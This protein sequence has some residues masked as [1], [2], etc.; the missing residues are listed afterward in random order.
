MTDYLHHYPYFPDD[1]QRKTRH[2]TLTQK[3]AFR[4]LLDEMWLTNQVDGTIPDDPTYCANVLRITEAEWLEIR[5]TLVEGPRPVLGCEDGRL[6]SRRLQEELDA[7]K[8]LV[9]IAR[10]NGKLGGRRSRLGTDRKPTANRPVKGSVSDGVPNPKLPEPEPEPRREN[11]NPL[12]AVPA[13]GVTE[14]KNSGEQPAMPSD[15]FSAAEAYN[16]LASELRV[17]RITERR[18]RKLVPEFVRL[19]REL[20]IP[21]FSLEACVD[22]LVE[23]RRSGTEFFRHWP[24]LD[25][26]WLLL[27]EK[28]GSRFNAWKVWHRFYAAGGREADRPQGLAVG[29]RTE[30]TEAERRSEFEWIRDAVGS[31]EREH[32]P[33]VTTEQ[34]R[35]CQRALGFGWLRWEELMAEFCPR[36]Q[37]ERTSE[38]AA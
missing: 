2:L 17:S 26:E 37:P 4:E 14:A 35:E 18:L 13:D 1:F 27:R 28:N 19:L 30:P 33:V 8:R 5:Q 6:Y 31:W 3:A 7:A 22:R 15:L 32:G 11:Q 20:D 36:G 21:E 10:E 23:Q 16:R 9:L 38:D 25:F 24:G 29:G 34:K 12:S